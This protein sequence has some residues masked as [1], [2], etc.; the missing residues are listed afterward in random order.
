MAQLK[1]CDPWMKVEEKV[2]LYLSVFPLMSDREVLFYAHQLNHRFL[3]HDSGIDEIKKNLN[4]R[5]CHVMMSATCQ[6]SSIG[7]RSKLLTN[8]RTL[9]VVDVT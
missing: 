7:Q 6:R 5:Q 4:S 2:L 8:Q 1:S 9:H 3:N